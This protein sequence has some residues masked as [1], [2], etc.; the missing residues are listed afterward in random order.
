MKKI[1]FCELT[2]KWFGYFPS[3]LFN[4]KRCL[5]SLYRN[6]RRH[7]E[8]AIGNVISRRSVSMNSF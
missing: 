4:L 7:T 6:K 2:R 8:N 3:I 5:S 1:A